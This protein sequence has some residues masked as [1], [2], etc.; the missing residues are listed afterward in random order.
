MSKQ[1]ELSSTIEVCR[2][3]VILGS[4]TWLSSNI[5]N[6]ELLIHSDFTIHRKDRSLSRGGGVLVAIQNCFSSLVVN[7]DTD[8]EVCFV[9][10][11]CAF[12]HILVGVC[13]RPPD[14][15]A[16][17]LQE[18]YKILNFV[19][20]RYPQCPVFLGGDF[21]Y[22]KIDWIDCVPESS[23]RSTSQCRDF[24]DICK[25][26]SLDQVVRVPT[27]ENAILDLFFTSIPELILS[28]N[29]V[30]AISDHRMVVIDANIAVHEKRC[31]HK[32]IFDYARANLSE[33]ASALE[34]FLIDFQDSFSL[35]S[36]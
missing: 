11:K 2:P 16:V 29:T 17:F 33:I 28:V 15:Q 20:L 14:S 27:R 9:R 23:C 1:D 13:Y 8:I 35:R 24:I 3:H 25:S 4:E 31:E 19:T 6:E 34:S 7:L 32:V 18:L 30:D 10:V 26:C 22:P 5:P 21:N 36:V 12:S